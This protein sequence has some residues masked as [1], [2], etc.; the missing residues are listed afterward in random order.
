MNVFPDMT[1]ISS[2]AD[3]NSRVNACTTEAKMNARTIH[4]FTLVMADDCMDVVC[5]EA[6]DDFMKF[7]IPA[8]AKA[9][10]LTNPGLEHLHDGSNISSTIP[11]SCGKNWCTS[12]GCK[13]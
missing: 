1:H 13:Q 6:H 2:K 7:M 11:L 9:G 5:R 4:G 8:G 3:V 10:K 12:Y